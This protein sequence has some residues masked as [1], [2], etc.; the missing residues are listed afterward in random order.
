MRAA[1]VAARKQLWHGNRPTSQ[2]SSGITESETR[3]F[4]S[5]RRHSAKGFNPKFQTRFLSFLAAKF[6]VAECLFVWVGLGCCA[7]VYPPSPP[8]HPSFA[9]APFGSPTHR[10][11]AEPTTEGKR[12]KRK[13]EA[14]NTRKSLLFQSA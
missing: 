6:R 8:P 9:P 2:A 12:G 5:S 14:A 1:P 11:K 4:N 10:F 7:Q 13:D 3:P